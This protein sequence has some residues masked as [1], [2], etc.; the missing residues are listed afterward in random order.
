MIQSVIV[1]E[2]AYKQMFHYV[3]EFANPDRPYRQWR[4]VIGWLVGKVD[5]ETITVIKAIPMTSGSSIFVEMSDYTII[6]K[7]AE[8]AEKANAVIVGWFHSHP[9]FG[10]FLSGVDIRT[11]RY[12]QSLFE[13][14]IALVCDPT[15]ITTIEPGMHGYQVYMD[16][17]Q[18][19]EYREL[20]LAIETQE[21]YPDMLKEMLLKYGITHSYS[22]IV[23][24][25]DLMDLYAL[26]GITPPNFAA[27]RSKQLL[28]SEQ[29]AQPILEGEYILSNIIK[30]KTDF[31]LQVRISNIG[32]GVAWNVDLIFDPGPDFKLSSMYPHRI[33]DQ[34][35]Y[36]SSIIET[37]KLKP[38]RTGELFL[39]R[40][41]INYKTA[42]DKKY[43]IVVPPVKIIID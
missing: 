28:P 25:E 2:E 30:Y 26:E 3:I 21:L 37:F 20:D 33:I 6:P 19:R 27:L 36:D 42:N 12:Q 35:N 34:L 11:Q 14:A 17:R 43:Y 32:E 18:G 16:E 1:T 9:S 31:Y 13:N 41:I 38:T 7:I 40:T 39:P 23:A 10:F 4:E 5:G 24:Y 15:K 29:N 22:E 8:E